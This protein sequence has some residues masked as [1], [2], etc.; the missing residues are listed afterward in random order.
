GNGLEL[1]VFPKHTA[2]IVS[3]VLLVKAGISA[4]PPGKNGLATLTADLLDE[5][6]GS[7]GTVELAEA[8]ERLGA[9]LSTAAGVEGSP[10]SMTVL[11]DKLD[12]AQELFADVA[13]APRFEPKD[14]ERLRG[15]QLGRIA[16]RRTDASSMATL[17]VMAALYGDGPYGRSGTGYESTVS[18]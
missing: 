15:E 4:D 7:R 12:A 6:A 13:L 3:M 11:A 1:I 17:N 2:P 8:L 10:V 5:G 9:E 18:K 14:V 16:Q